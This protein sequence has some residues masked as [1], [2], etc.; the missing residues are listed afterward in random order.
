MCLYMKSDS[1]F[2]IKRNELLSP[3]AGCIGDFN[4]IRTLAHGLKPKCDRVT[5]SVVFI[6]HFI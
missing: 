6:C 2:T 4:D 3:T 1:I 5:V